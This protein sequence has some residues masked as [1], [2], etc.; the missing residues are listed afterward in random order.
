MLLGRFRLDGKKESHGESQ[1]NQGRGRG[2]LPRHQPRCESGVSFEE[3]R[4]QGYGGWID[5]GKSRYFMV[6]L[7]DLRNIAFFGRIAQRVAE[8]S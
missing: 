2:A 1:Q 8:S 6:L 5:P 7:H 4:N 3:R